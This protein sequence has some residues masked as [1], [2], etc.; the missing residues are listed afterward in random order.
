MSNIITNGIVG[1]IIFFLG[2][3]AGDLLAKKINYAGK[4]VLNLSREDKDIAQFVLET[5]LDEIS[6][7][8][9]IT[10]KVENRS[11]LKSLVDYEESQKIHRL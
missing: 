5:P 6:T 7:R 2:L 3:V 8:D 1:A 4:L 11:N 10:I 9:Y